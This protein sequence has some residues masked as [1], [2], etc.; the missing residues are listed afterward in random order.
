MNTD[1]PDDH[2]TGSDGP[3]HAPY[4]QTPYGQTPYGQDAYG[5]AQYGQPSYGQPSYGQAAY[6]Q[7]AGGYPGL[8]LPAK[9]HPSATTSMVLGIVGL[10]GGF[11]CGVFILLSPVAWVMGART[12]REIDA[13]G[14]R[15]SG[16]EQANVG[17]VLGIVGTVIL[18]LILIVV[19][20]IIALAVTSEPSSTY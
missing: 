20:V 3:E 13:S 6:G 9:P 7:A 18:V 5:Q 1:R 15:Y 19:A 16:R 4:G 12:V 17:K 2:P 14:G 10:V 11:L 8:P